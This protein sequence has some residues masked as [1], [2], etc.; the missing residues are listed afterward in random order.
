M[1]RKKQTKK[2][3][4]I[5]LLPEAFILDRIESLSEAL[6]AYGVQGILEEFTRWLENGRFICRDTADQC[7]RWP[8]K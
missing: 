7:V 1:P 4:R 6:A 5:E 8:K 2:S 3:F